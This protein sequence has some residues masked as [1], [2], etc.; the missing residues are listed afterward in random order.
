MN[1][2]GIEYLSKLLASSPLTSWNGTV[3]LPLTEERVFAPASFISLLPGNRLCLTRDN[4]LSPGSYSW[5]SARPRSSRSPPRSL[6]A[7]IAST[8]M[9]W[10]PGPTDFALHQDTSLPYGTDGIF[11]GRNACSR[12]CRIPSPGL[13]PAVTSGRI[14]VRSMYASSH[15]LAVTIAGC[16]YSVIFG[17]S[18]CAGSKQRSVIETQDPL[19]LLKHLASPFPFPDKILSHASGLCA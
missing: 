11:V 15:R 4:N 5:Q 12:H 8:A 6:S 10:R 9:T 16:V 14:P 19:C 17:R 1:L 18:I 2:S 13:E 7:S 3:R